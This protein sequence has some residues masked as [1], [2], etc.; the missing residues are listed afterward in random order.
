MWRKG[1][2]RRREIGRQ[3][4]EI[5]REQYNQEACQQLDVVKSEVMRRGVGRW[6]RD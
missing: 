6:E 4:Q 2:K 5:V 1:K 3:L